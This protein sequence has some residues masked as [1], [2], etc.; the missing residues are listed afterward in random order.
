[1]LIIL[2]KLACSE[3]QLIFVRFKSGLKTIIKINDLILKEEKF[4]TLNESREESH[5]QT[6]IIRHTVFGYQKYK[7]IKKF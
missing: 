5:K 2:L 1:M 4:D 3:I 7:L 6:R